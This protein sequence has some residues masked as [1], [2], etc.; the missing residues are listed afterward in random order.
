MRALSAL[1]SAC[2]WRRC[3]AGRERRL[4]LPVLAP[5][6]LTCETSPALAEGA[7]AVTVV[8]S[9]SLTA[10]QVTLANGFQYVN[11]MTP[12]ERRSRGGAGVPVGRSLRMHAWCTPP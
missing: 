12:C 9:D 8:G 5:P 4:R 7:F 11:W 2:A 1:I 6:Q 3:G 10:N